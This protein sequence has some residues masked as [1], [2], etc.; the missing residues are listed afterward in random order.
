MA[1]MIRELRKAGYHVQ[2]VAIAA[3][4]PAY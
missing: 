4:N 1:R 2:K 3:A